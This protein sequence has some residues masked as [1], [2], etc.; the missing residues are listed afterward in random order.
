MFGNKQINKLALTAAGLF[1]L[2]TASTDAAAWRPPPKPQPKPL[3]L[4]ESPTLP[5][6]LPFRHAGGV[7]SSQL[8]C[9]LSGRYGQWRTR[10]WHTLAGTNSSDGQSA[11][12]PNLLLSNYERQQQLPFSSNTVNAGRWPFV[13]PE[14]HWFQA[15]G[16]KFGTV[17]AVSI[18][19]KLSV[20]AQ[21]L[22]PWL[23]RLDHGW[24]QALLSLLGCGRG[25]S[26]SP[27]VS[28]PAQ[29]FEKLWVALAPKQWPIPA[30]KCRRRE[31]TIRRYGREADTFELVRC[32]GSVPPDALDRLSLL[33]RPVGVARPAG[34]LPDEPTADPDSG[35]WVPDIKLVHPR[36]LWVLNMIARKFPYRALYL[37]SGYRRCSRPSKPGSEQSRH[38]G[39]RALDISVQG[40]PNEDLFSFCRDLPDTGCGYYPNE[41][42][43]HVDV[44]RRGFGT[45]IWVDAAESGQPARYVDSWPGVV[46]PGAIPWANPP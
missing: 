42:F 8:R 16:F 1:V 22:P 39:G 40:V 31:V 29:A 5:T 28:F 10:P 34:L 2:F 6:L 32:D 27:D 12:R 19:P 38:C 26:C 41:K 20:S 37:F 30:W 36:L 11:D 24:A 33:A 3:R 17:D 7:P 13:R 35:E 9:Y 44:R 15:D 25:G 43:V 21:L 23:R 46:E 45:V 4:D 18:E 14:Q